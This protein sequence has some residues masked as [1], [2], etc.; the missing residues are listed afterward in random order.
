MTIHGVSGTTPPELPP[1]QAE[2]SAADD[3]AS[4]AQ[5]VTRG[6]EGVRPRIPGLMPTNDVASPMMSEDLAERAAK[7]IDDLPGIAAPFTSEFV[8][9]WDDGDEAVVERFV[10]SAV[11]DDKGLYA[12][13]M[14]KLGFG[15]YAEWLE[16]F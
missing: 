10:R 11:G 16:A 1:S 6:G 15:P 2:T 5:E 13:T 8:S 9:A 3:S 12:A 4:A 7:L 14:E